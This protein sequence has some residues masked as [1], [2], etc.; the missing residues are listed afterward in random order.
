MRPRALLIEPDFS[1]HRWR[2]AKW[3]A[4]ALEESGYSCVIATNA[5]NRTHP[6]VE[7]L[8]IERPEVAFSF[9]RPQDIRASIVHRAL[10]AAKQ[11]FRFHG[12][13]SAIYRA[14]CRE[15]RIDLV[16]VP[17][18]DYF[19][20]AMGLLGSPFGATP[21]LCIVMR[22]SFHLREMGVEVPRRPWLD[23]VKRQLYFLALRRGKPQAVLTIDPTLAI[24][25]ARSRGARFRARVEYLADP[26]PE[27]API[28]RDAARERLKLPPALTI[29]VYGAISDRKGIKELV[30]ACLARDTH[31]LVV[32][33]GRQSDDVRAFLAA[34]A[35]QLGER[36]AIFDRFISA[37]M[38]ADL[39]AACDAVWVGY[40]GHFGMSGVLVQAY[41]FGKPVLATREG[42]IGWFTRHDRLGPLL[43]DLSIGAVNAA[44]D[45]AFAPA[46]GH[47]QPLEGGGAEKLLA[48]NTVANFKKTLQSALAGG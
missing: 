3:C 15:R 16:V 48:R 25:H 33:A 1:G 2:Y 31:P 19:F 18:G 36:I 32:V 42:L 20:N 24:W 43:G 44:I 47:R 4:E 13:F 9:H 5:S 12:T 41:R 21:W 14:T 38:E 10:G 34:H 23:Q 45:E 37:E 30:N 46:F 29:L 7:E 35:P 26:F 40:K 39:F 17:Y 11:D 28:A 22:Q 8:A 27:V 6:V